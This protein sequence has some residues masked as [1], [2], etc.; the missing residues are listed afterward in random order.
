M[1][2]ARTLRF[3]ALIPFVIFYTSSPQL[4]SQ[5]PRQQTPEVIFRTETALI[6][7]EVRVKDRQGQPVDGLDKGDFTV[8]ENDK[9]Q[10]IA[11]VEFISPIQ[12]TDAATA[13]DS[14]TL[15]DQVATLPPEEQLRKSTLIYI[16]SWVGPEERERVSNTIRDFVEQQLRPG[17]L[18]SIQGAPFTGSKPRLLATLDAA[19]RRKNYTG[20]VDVQSGTNYTEDYRVLAEEL[21]EFDA[22]GLGSAIRDLRTQSARGMLLR[23][24]DL[25]Q[26]LSIYPG[27]KK[28]VLFSRAI[29]IGRSMTPE[30]TDL[31]KILEKKALR[32]RV[33]FFVMGMAG[34][35]ALTDESNASRPF[36][37]ADDP[38]S[39]SGAVTAGLQAKF[40]DG[41]RGLQILASQTG[42]EAL[43]NS[44]DL[45]EVF[46]KVS[47]D[48]E[49]YYVLGYYPGDTRQLGRR[50]KIRVAVSR[51]GLRLD[52]L[53][54]Y[55]EEKSYSRMTGSEKRLQIERAIL[56]TIPQ[57][58]IEVTAG[59]EVFR[60]PDGQPQLAYSLGV[61]LA[62]A[63]SDSP[64]A[65]EPDYSAVVTVRDEAEGRLHG[66]G[67]HRIQARPASSVSPGNRDLGTELH[68]P[69]TISLPPGNYKVKTLIRN[70]RTG[71]LGSIESALEV[72]AFNRP[73]APSSLMLTTRATKF[74]SVSRG[75]SA[76]KPND[77]ARAESGR[78]IQAAGVEFFPESKRVFQRGETIY[79]IY[80]VYN[81]S[82][83][84]LTAPPGPRVFLMQG[85]S[86]L[87]R[88]PF[89]SYEV[90]PSTE[91]K[92]LRYVAKLDTATLEPG[93]Y[94]LVVP[95]PNSEQAI[96]QKFSLSGE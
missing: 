82:A 41:Q 31:L 59:Y 19:G 21:K 54:G 64:A 50:R 18:V 63:S 3:T 14:P 16:A 26:K 88:P 10:Q 51:P 8:F 6:E 7:V 47:A 49:S 92:E 89:R 48:L 42:G 23:A 62:H 79:M 76:T 24:I 93:D 36:L 38:A 78:G 68:L 28:V 12:P 35:T 58:G 39:T 46:D 2:C 11:N 61:A 86:Q 32:A 72:P 73:A 95:L 71:E 34:L 44:N 40:Q 65:G 66:F 70:E 15:S 57:T 77:L 30:V 1:N 4:F 55:E 85:E 94:N 25:I 33:R 13:T 74:L 90:F 80:D 96:F 60:G 9:P 20:L 84:L 37:N 29:P 52:Y 22:E 81:V 69:A 75:V 83:E 17:M 67:G 45:G 53:Q 5:Q 56:S 91:R 27:S 43:V 87:D